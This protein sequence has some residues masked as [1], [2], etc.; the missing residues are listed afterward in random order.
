[1]LQERFTD[2]SILYTEKSIPKSIDTDNAIN[3]FAEKNWF[4]TFK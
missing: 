1:M 2:I 4:T 3:K